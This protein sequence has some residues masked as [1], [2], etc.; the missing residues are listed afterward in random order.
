LVFNFLHS[1]YKRGSREIYPPALVSTSCEQDE[2]DSDAALDKNGILY[3]KGHIRC[4]AVTLFFVQMFY[5]TASC[6]KCMYDSA[7]VNT[8]KSLLRAT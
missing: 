6:E 5:Y 2:V 7:V 3:A 4:Y 1:V 8:V